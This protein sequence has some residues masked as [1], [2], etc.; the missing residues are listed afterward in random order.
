M[1]RHNDTG[2]EGE[3][4]A[5]NWFVNQGYHV[6]VANWRSGRFEVD[7]IAEKNNVLHFIEVKTKRGTAFGLPEEQV[8]KKKIRH[9]LDAAEAYVYQHPQ[10]QRVQFDVLAVILRKAAD[11]EYFLIEDV[12]E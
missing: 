11:P 2:K 9:L 7:L 6:I 5:K 12:Y 3:T 4:L 10:W 8:S 1:A